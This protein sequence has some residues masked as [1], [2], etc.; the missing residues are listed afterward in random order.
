MK[1]QTQSLLDHLDTRSPAPPECSKTKKKRNVFLERYEKAASTKGS[2]ERGASTERDILVKR[3][4]ISGVTD[5]IG[6]AAKI[7]SCT[8][9]VI[10]NLENVVKLPDPPI[11]EIQKLTD[12]LEEIGEDLQKEKGD[13]SNSASKSEAFATSQ[14]SASSSAS[15]SGSSISSSNSSSS[16][17]SSSTGGR[18]VCAPTCTTCVNSNAARR[19]R[20]EQPTSVDKRTLEDLHNYDGVAEFVL[21]EKS[22]YFGLPPW[23][24]NALP[25][26][27]DFL[28]S[29]N[30]DL[31]LSCL[32]QSGNPAV[33]SLAIVSLVNFQTH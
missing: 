5:L 2:Y 27:C 14:T 30:Y 18:G 12:V 13:P 31:V 21:D 16:S 24:Y 22:E 33:R 26:Y 15:L 28:R 25:S 19:K 29:T 23:P 7:L 4:L 1:D 8:C 3:S 6:N 17:S 9:E 32:K 20:S 11:N 10:T